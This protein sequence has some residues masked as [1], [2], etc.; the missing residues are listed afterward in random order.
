MKIF[1]FLSTLFGFKILDQK[2][3]QFWLISKILYLPVF[4]Q[5]QRKK[6]LITEPI[7][8]TL[9]TVIKTNT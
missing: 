5:Q 6:S 9:C 4:Y 3:S 1:N 2:K 8:V 7:L